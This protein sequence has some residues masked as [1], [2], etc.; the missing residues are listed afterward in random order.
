MLRTIEE[1]AQLGEKK[2]FGG[3]RI[4]MADIAFGVVAHWLVGVFE[5]LVGV[6]LLEADSFPLLCKWA[7]NFK[8]VPEIKENLPDRNEMPK[9]Y[10]GLRETALLAKP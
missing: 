2:F 7:Q 4:G 5:E 10:N 3:E 8:E 1:H 6:K 9:F